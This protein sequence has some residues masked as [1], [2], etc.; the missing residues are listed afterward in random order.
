MLAI[1]TSESKASALAFT[2]SSVP[3]TGDYSDHRFADIDGDGDLDLI[4]TSV[5]HVGIEGRRRIEIFKQNDRRFSQT[6]SQIVEVPGDASLLFVGDASSSPGL[7]I[8]WYHRYGVRILKQ[9]DGKFGEVAVNALGVRTFFD[10]ASTDSLLFGEFCADVDGDGL[11]DIIVPQ[12][13]NYIVYFRSENDTFDRYQ[14]FFTDVDISMNEDRNALVRAEYA[15]PII[16]LVDF[17]GDGLL[18]FLTTFR[19]QL[20]V[21]FQRSKGVF[22]ENPSLRTDLDELSSSTD[23][24][25]ESVLSTIFQLGDFDGDKRYDIVFVRNRGEFGLFSGFKTEVLLFLGNGENLGLRVEG[26]GRIPHQILRFEGVGSKPEFGDFDKDGDQDLSFTVG[27]LDLM[28][29][30]GAMLS[31]HITVEYRLISF[32]G[33]L[34]RFDSEIAFRSELDIPRDFFEGGRDTAAVPAIRFPGDFNGDGLVDL[35]RTEPIGGGTENLRYRIYESQRSS[36]F[37]F[38]SSHAASFDDF[39]PTFLPTF[40][41]LN[42]DGK[43]DIVNVWKST[44]QIAIMN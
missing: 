26:G 6:P 18:D 7:E 29:G 17:N 22:D 44:L 28:S 24:E 3:L 42:G 35:F 25:G 5:S 31:D 21:F 40:L 8:G 33:Q 23:E 11:S 20:V 30:I 41:D 19:R 12:Q 32:S 4:A 10:F 2:E 34:R 43:T 37:A 15:L 36:G 9:S 14:S 1:L 16:N 13:R 27:R 39:T 38:A